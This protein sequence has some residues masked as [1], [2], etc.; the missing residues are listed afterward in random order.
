LD[1]ALTTD[2]AALLDLSAAAA[3]AAMRGG[4]LA[5]ES[6][7][8]SLQASTVDVRVDADDANFHLSIEDDG[9]G[10][11]MSVKDLDSPASLTASR[12][13]AAR[14]TSPAAPDVGR[15]CA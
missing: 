6:Y 3:V 5:A 14:W 10:E 1:D 12:R 13:S 4:V 11:P 9:I 2:D 8:R 15:L 7:A